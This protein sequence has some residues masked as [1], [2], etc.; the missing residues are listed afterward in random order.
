MEV[1]SS[2]LSVVASLADSEAELSR[3]LAEAPLV[4]ASVESEAVE[5]ESSTDERGVEVVS[6]SVRVD[7]IVV[8]V[9]PLRVESPGSTDE[10]YHVLLSTEVRGRAVSSRVSVSVP[11]VEAVDKVTVSEALAVPVEVVCPDVSDDCEGIT[12]VVTVSSAVEAELVVPEVPLES[13]EVTMSVWVSVAVAA[14]PSVGVSLGEEPSVIDS[15]V[16][17]ADEVACS[18]PTEVLEEPPEAVSP[19]PDVSVDEKS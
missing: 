12:S 19:S 2:S 3:A 13:V 4:E 11:E 17:V 9:V 18:V 8:L 14:L 16:I 15:V 5:A 1:P 10:V 6:V 7:L